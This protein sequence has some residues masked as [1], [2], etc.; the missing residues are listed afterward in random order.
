MILMREYGTKVKRPMK[1][2]SNFG[3]TDCGYCGKLYTQLGI[4]RHWDHCHKNPNRKVK[5]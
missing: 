5:S 4:S 1:R 2:G 3:F